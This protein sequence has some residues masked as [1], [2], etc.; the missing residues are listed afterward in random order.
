MRHYSCL[1]LSIVIWLIT[2][3]VTGA[4]ATIHTVHSSDPSIHYS[5]PAID[6]EDQDNGGH[7]VSRT[8]TASAVFPFTGAFLPYTF[9]AAVVE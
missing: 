8:H 1:G 9:V 6:W 3:H 4:W 7:M 2:F 5:N